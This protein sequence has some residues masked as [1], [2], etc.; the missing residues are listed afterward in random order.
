MTLSYGDISLW[1]VKASGS[2]LSFVFELLCEFFQLGSIISLNLLAHVLHFGPSDRQNWVLEYPEGN[3]E[4]I[5]AIPSDFGERWTLK[6]IWINNHKPRSL[7]TW[8]IF[9]FLAILHHTMEMI[10][11]TS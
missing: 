4:L 1:K 2:C 7:H 5:N 8:F 6:N 3:L 9:M 10:S 11:K